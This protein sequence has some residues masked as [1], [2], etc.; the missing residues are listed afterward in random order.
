MQLSEQK[1]VPCHGGVP[2]LTA[3]EARSLHE[4]VKSWQL[5][6]DRLE[7]E[8]T[9]GDFM[10]AIRFINTI[11][12]L[13][14]QEGHHPDIHNYYNKVRFVLTTHAIGGLSKN[15]FILASKIDR[16]YDHLLNSASGGR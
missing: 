10:A 7:R 4:Q 13:A 6:P 16:A 8:L 3:E 1:C 12:P 9:F 15:D 11:A 5:L 2:V 14:E